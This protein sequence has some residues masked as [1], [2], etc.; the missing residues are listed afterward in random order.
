MSVNEII[1]LS[2]MLSEII[3][4]TRIKYKKKAIMV[5]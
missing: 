1:R 4:S 2:G 5:A 3:T